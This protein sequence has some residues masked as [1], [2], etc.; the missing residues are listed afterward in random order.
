MALDFPNTPV[1]GQVYNNFI[2]DASKGTWKSLS[3]GASPSILEDPTITNATIT[4]AIITATATTPST[5]PITVK[6]AA[7][8]S[9]NLQEW[10]DSNEIVVSSMDQTGKLFAQDLSLLKNTAHIEIG[11][12]T[13]TA[14]TPYIDFHSGATATDFDSRIIASGGNGTQSN[15]RL[16]IYANVVNFLG[17][18][19]R[20]SQPSFLVRN[21]EFINSTRTIVF[22][23]VLHNNGSHYNSSNGRFTAPIAGYYLFNFQTLIYDMGT[24][25]ACWFGLNG[26][27]QYTFAG[28]YGQ[29][30]GTYAGQSAS[31]VIYLN[32]NDYV[33]VT[34]TYNS[35][36]LHSNYTIFSGHLLS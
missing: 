5:V 36:K 10:K 4:D 7:S 25:S 27:S 21:N 2:Y 6:G 3:S 13:G 18:G 28:V 9:A 20:A 11:G 32:A 26:T 23:E 19:T 12:M 31:V 30:S 29:H 15:G 14:N 8:Q 33:Y 16:D 24:S 22:G 1:D 35:T 34:F 17:R